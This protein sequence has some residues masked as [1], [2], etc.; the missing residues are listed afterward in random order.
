MVNKNKLGKDKIFIEN[1]L[2]WEER[3]VQEKIRK[4]V[5]IRV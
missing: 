1:N 4:Q 3:K 2:S 5:K